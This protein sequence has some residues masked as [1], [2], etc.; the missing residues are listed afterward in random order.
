MPGRLTPDSPEPLASS[1][2][3]ERVPEVIDLAAA[4][5]D[6]IDL[7][8]DAS[9]VPLGLLDLRVIAEL[10]AV[11]RIRGSFEHLKAGHSSLLRTAD[12]LLVVAS[13]LFENDQ[14][15]GLFEQ[16]RD[17]AASM[18]PKKTEISYHGY[19]QSDTNLAEYRADPKGCLLRKVNLRPKRKEARGQDA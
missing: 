9:Q 14:I 4:L 11:A 3:T 15:M 18:L 2:A 12:K 17:Y 1:P 16:N 19:N 6:V 8:A 10:L 7:T 5:H 13:R